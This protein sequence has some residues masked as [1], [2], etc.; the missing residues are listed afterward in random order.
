[1]QATAI[2]LN[3]L[4]PSSATD[5]SGM[6]RH[7]AAFPAR[8]MQGWK[9]AGSLSLPPEYR[10]VRHIVV[11]GMGGSA[12]AGDIAAEALDGLRPADGRGPRIDVF[13]DYGAHPAVG[14]DSLVILMSHSGRT[15]E[16]LSGLEASLE[17]GARLI[18]MTGGG[19]LAQAAQEQGIPITMM[20]E[21]GGPPRAYLPYAFGAL[22]RILCELDIAP[23][24]AGRALETAVKE[25]RDA[26][27]DFAPTCN[28]T[29]AGRANPAKELARGLV[30]RVPIIVSARGL[31]SA[32]RRWKTQF[33]ENAK[34]SAWTEELPEMHHNAVV[35]LEQAELSR[36]MA[37]I[38]LGPLSVDEQSPV[39]QRYVIS[40]DVFSR[41]NI[42]A[43]WPRLRGTSALARLLEAV[44][45]G[46][47]VSYYL[48]LVSG[49]DPTPTETLDRVKARMRG[50]AAPGDGHME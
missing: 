17:R 47:Y 18:A 3:D 25:L 23:P 30:G 44:L 46:D 21:N 14:P 15:E 33:N 38:L 16:A 29:E 28:Q 36:N 43:H 7:I 32:A 49:I 41:V 5:P 11:Q 45:L 22:L 9:G 2:D 42:P 26:Q 48:A 10:N 1:M 39:H 6:G 4:P 31:A 35:G 27:A 19:P 8:I 34:T 24:E 37:A 12:I 50:G 20:P 13:R 40:R